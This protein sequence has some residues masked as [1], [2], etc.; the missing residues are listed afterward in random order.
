MGNGS[1]LLKML[2]PAIRPVQQFDASSVK[3][4]DLPF[5]QKDFDALLAEAKDI[6]SVPAS[7][8]MVG[9]QDVAEDQ[10][11]ILSDLTRIDSV[12]NAS[13]RDVFE[14]FI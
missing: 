4:S 13:L 12:E 5:E 6:V 3:R 10:Q 2:E 1:D 7:D 11:N 14:E 8:T 9:G